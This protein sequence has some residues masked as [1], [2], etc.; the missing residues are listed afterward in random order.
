MP[1][2]ASAHGEL[3]LA[4]THK[5]PPFFVRNFVSQLPSCCKLEIGHV[6][7]IYTTEIGK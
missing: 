6:G 2:Q 3:E 1:C 7:S 5:R 4:S